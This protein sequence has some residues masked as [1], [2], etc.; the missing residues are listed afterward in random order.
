M[1]ADYPIPT[2]AHQIPAKTPFIS[3][4]ITPDTSHKAARF[5]KSLRDSSNIIV[6]VHSSMEPEWINF[7]Q[8]TYVRFL[9]N[10]RCRN[11]TRVCHI[12]SHGTKIRPYTRQPM[13]QICTSIPHVGD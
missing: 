4:K 10:Y 8:Q 9:L 13:I 7:R 12:Q 6:H 3:L 11:L 2:A 1:L 5:L